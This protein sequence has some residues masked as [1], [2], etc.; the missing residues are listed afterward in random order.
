MRTTDLMN[1][2][3][4]AG[5]CGFDRLNTGYTQCTQRW[6]MRHKSCDRLRTGFIEPR[7]REVRA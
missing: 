2:L 7:T 6:R 3:T 5:L 1:L 4:A